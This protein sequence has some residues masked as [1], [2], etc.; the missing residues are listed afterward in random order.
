MYI[1]IGMQ[2]TPAGMNNF[3]LGRYNEYIEIVKDQISCATEASEILQSSYRNLR[4]IDVPGKFFWKKNIFLSSTQT[5]QT[6][7]RQ[8]NTNNQNNRPG[9]VAPSNPQSPAVSSP[10]VAGGGGGGPTTPGAI[11]APS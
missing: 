10:G 3:E 7:R 4:K 1:K 6:Q 8:Q 11:V 2:G 5:G 9:S